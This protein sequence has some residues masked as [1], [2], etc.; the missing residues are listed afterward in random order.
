MNKAAAL[1]KLVRNSATQSGGPLRSMPN[2]KNDGTNPSFS[3]KPRSH[4]PNADIDPSSTPAPTL[5]GATNT[6]IGGPIA[7]ERNVISKSGLWGEEGFPDG[8]Q[9]GISGSDGT[10]FEGNFVGTTPDGLSAEYQIGPYGVQIQSSDHVLVRNNVIGGIAISGWNHAEG[11]RFGT[12]LEL[13]GNCTN[14]VV[15]GNKIGTDV[16]GMNPLP[17]RLNVHVTWAVD[18]P[19][20]HLFGGP[21]PEEA[22]V[23]AFSETSGVMVASGVSAVTITRNS[24]FDNQMLG[25]ELAPAA[26]GDQPAPILSSAKIGNSIVTISG[27]ITGQP[28]QRHAIEFFANA[29]CDP[30]GFGEGRL[31]LVEAIVITDS[32]GKANFTVSVP[33]GSK[34]GGVITATAT[35]LVSGNTSEFSA[36]RTIQSSRTWVPYHNTTSGDRL[37]NW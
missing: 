6:R 7:A 16:T 17:N 32:L 34:H 2:M 19:V 11:L 12:G 26:N 22:N 24:I 28:S 23:I 27:S 37:N 30:L 5:R 1:F 33:A 15:Q 35:N 21:S 20:N 29:A 3:T 10:V 25:I 9:V 4:A 13:D 36:C 14:A 8:G 18:G 31:F